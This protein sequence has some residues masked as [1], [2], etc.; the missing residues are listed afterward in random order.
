MSPLAFVLWVFDAATGAASRPVATLALDGDAW[1]VSWMPLMW[2]D[3]ARWQTRLAG[4]AAP[5]G[6][7]LEEWTAIGG[8]VTDVVELEEIPPARDLQGVAEMAMDELL[9]QPDPSW[10]R[11]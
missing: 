9:A 11:R 10:W 2:D 6:E 8:V 4:L 1:A 5:I 7:A 3:A